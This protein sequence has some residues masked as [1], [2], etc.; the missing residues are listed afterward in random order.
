MPLAECAGPG[1][2]SEQLSAASK[3]IQ[4]AIAVEVQGLIDRNSSLAS[5]NDPLFTKA[6]GELASASQ[7]FATGCG[8]FPQATRP[9]PAPFDG[10]L[11]G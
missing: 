10:G 11:S 7:Q 2:D 4:S 1:R 9:S 8:T 3:A 5:G 6:A